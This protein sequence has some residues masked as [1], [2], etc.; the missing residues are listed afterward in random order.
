MRLGRALGDHE[1]GR[2]LPVARPLGDEAADL[3]LTAGQA[4]RRAGDRERG[5]ACFSS[6]TKTTLSSRLAPAVT[7]EA[8]VN[9]FAG[10]FLI[11]ASSLRLPA[12]L[13]SSAGRLP[14]V[15]A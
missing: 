2:D 15:L 14:E 7:S 12:K 6:S 5:V 9:E 3:P 8:L 13:V 10:G 11:S 1:V 4:A